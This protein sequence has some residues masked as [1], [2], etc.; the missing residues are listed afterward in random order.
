MSSC[1]PTW[2]Q[3][4]LEDGRV[5]WFRLATRLG[6][7]FGTYVYRFGPSPDDS[8]CRT[9]WCYGDRGRPWRCDVCRED[10]DAPMRGFS[11]TQPSPGAE[12]RKRP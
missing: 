4:W 3:R 2:H 7:A 1:G 8:E 6:N 12:P 10:I 11:A 9:I 5:V